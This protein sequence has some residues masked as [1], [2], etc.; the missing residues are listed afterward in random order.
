MR[1]V[2]TKEAWVLRLRLR[3]TKGVCEGLLRVV[4]RGNGVGAPVGAPVMSGG[5]AAAAVAVRGRGFRD[6]GESELGRQGEGGA[7][8]GEEEGEVGAFLAAFLALPAGDEGFDGVGRGVR[9][10]LMLQCLSYCV[11]P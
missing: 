2:E 4:A 1:G 6:G 3:M 9:Y 7:E 11:Q 10:C 5:A 8:L